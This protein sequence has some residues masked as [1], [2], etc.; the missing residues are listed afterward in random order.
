MTEAAKEARRAYLREWARNN[1]E[2]VKAHQE[3]YWAKKAAE[4][5]A[6]REQSKPEKPEE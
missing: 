5:E 6:R 4:Q 2:K 3:K 1:P